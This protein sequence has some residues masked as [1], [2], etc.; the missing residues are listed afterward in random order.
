MKSRIPSCL[1]S[2][3]AIAGPLNA[4]TLLLSDAFNDPGGNTDASTFN[5]NLAS[6]QGGTLATV[7]YTTQGGYWTVQHS[8]SPG[9]MLLANSGG[10]D[11]VA[12]VSLNHDFAVDANLADLP[13]SVSFNIVGVSSFTDSSRWVQFNIG[14]GQNL[15]VA[16]G[17]VGAGVYFRQAGTADGLS[18]ST[19]MFSNASWSP[20]DLVTIT[21]ADTAGTGSAFNGNGS[22]ATIT[23]GTTNIGTFTLAQQS[24]ANLTFSAFNY[25][26]DQFGIGQFSNLAVTLVPEPGVALLGSLG[27]LVLF[28]RRRI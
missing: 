2:F 6:T 25:G 4:T 14:N 8:N 16:D 5:N 15:T 28:R 22:T 20:N 27:M 19:G 10:N 1:V 3:L 11:T 7:S 18:A 9:V 13:L 26:N 12:S 17:N 24:V 21:L 23:I